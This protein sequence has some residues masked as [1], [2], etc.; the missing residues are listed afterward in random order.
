MG[1][2]TGSGGEEDWLGRLEEMGIPITARRAEISAGV[3]KRPS[4]GR[5]KATLGVLGYSC[6]LPAKTHDMI[7]FSVT[8]LSFAHFQ[9]Q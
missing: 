4:L 1:T 2:V 3:G 7:V 8:F 6:A 5:L 9:G